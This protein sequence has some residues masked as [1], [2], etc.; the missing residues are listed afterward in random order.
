MGTLEDFRQVMS[1]VFSGALRVPLDRTYPLA[2]AAAAQRRL[3]RGEQMG[4]I[5]LQ[6]S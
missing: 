5:T 4:K 1:L 6:I 3:E 2:E